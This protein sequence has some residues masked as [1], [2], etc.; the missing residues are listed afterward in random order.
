MER[1][2]REVKTEQRGEKLENNREVR[3][4]REKSIQNGERVK[5]KRE[6]D[7][8]RWNGESK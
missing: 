4:D 8:S 5:K 3:K 6:R 2:K 1:E 7:E